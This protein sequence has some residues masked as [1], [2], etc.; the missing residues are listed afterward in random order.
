MRGRSKG[1]DESLKLL[2]GHKLELTDRGEEGQWG[3]RGANALSTVTS[4]WG[5]DL[6]EGWTLG[7]LNG[8]NVSVDQAPLFSHFFFYEFRWPA[9]RRKLH[10]KLNVFRF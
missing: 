3:E 1:P 9:H 7:H 2:F 10:I 6:R 8:E 5:I 4:D